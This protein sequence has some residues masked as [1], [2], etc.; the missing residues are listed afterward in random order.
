MN[1]IFDR[2]GRTIAWVRDK[3]IYDL[4]GKQV[5]AFINNNSVFTYQGKHL[6]RFNKGFFRDK[7][8]HAVAFVKGATGGPVTPVT[9]VTPISPIPSIPAIPP[10]PPIPPIAPIDSLSWSNLSWENFINQ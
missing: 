8:G 6:G 9:Q 3:Y 4:S 10:I 5:L 7:N 1:S 2:Q